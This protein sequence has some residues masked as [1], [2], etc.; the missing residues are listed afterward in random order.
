MSTSWNV[1]FLEV[2]TIEHDLLDA[3]CSPAGLL[4]S[5]FCYNEL[6][7]CDSVLNIVILELMLLFFSTK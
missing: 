1:V 2:Y 7:L 6:S 5:G 3:L 4:Y